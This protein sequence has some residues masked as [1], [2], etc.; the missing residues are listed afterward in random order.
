M[1]RWLSGLILILIST[2]LS[3][4]ESTA[5][6]VID[7][8]AGA[9]HYLEYEGKPIFLIGDSVTQG[10]VE[11]GPDF[12]QEAYLEALG[13][14]GIR[15]LLLWSFIA[16]QTGS[17]QRIGYDAPELLP[18]VKTGPTH[19]DLKRLEDR[20]F[21][22]L[23]DLCRSAEN[24]GI[25]VIIQIFDGWTKTRFSTHPFN[26]ANGGP[27]TDRSQFVDLADYENE[28]PAEYNT[29]WNR[30][31]RN[32]YFQERFAARI[33]ETTSSFGNVAYELFNEGEWYDREKRRRH[34][35]H[36]LAFFKARCSNLLLTNADH[37]SGFDPR[38]EPEADV[39]SFHRPNWSCST[40]A[41]VSFDHFRSQFV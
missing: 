30:R 41:T 1:R 26:A 18:W 13:R 39:V 40:A 22:R 17:D 19:W 28:M 11:S 12:D 36:F 5:L 4:A 16:P 23:A 29:G 35:V 2:A 3:G 32:Q 33:I 34:E 31:Q 8:G 24:R 14:R 21:A 10:W 9:H 38:R 27:L 25:C 37:I 7:S 6:S 15:A 20:Y